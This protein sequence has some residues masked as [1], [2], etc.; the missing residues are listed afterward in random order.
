MNAA[1]RTVRVLIVEGSAAI[2][3]LLRSALSRDGGIAVVGEAPDPHAARELITMLNP[4]VLILDVETPEM[5]GLEFLEE[6]MRRRP[7]PVVTVSTLTGRGADVTLD[8]LALGAADYVPKPADN[9]AAHPDAAA[10]ELIA[11]VRAAAT[12][13]IRTAA[14]SVPHRA[15]PPAAP[16]ASH[17]FADRIIAIGASTGGV[18]AV[19]ELLSRF[20]AN[21]PP[22]LIT[23]P[24]PAGMTASF[25]ARLDKL[26]APWVSEATDCAPLVP[27]QVWLAPG[28]G[29]HLEV[30][31]RIAPR[32]RLVPDGPAGGHCPSVDRLFHSL[33][34][35][36]PRRTV[37]V[38]LT[39]MGRD[40]ADGLGALALAGGETVGQDE[41]SCAVYGMARAAFEMGAVVHQLPLER[42]GPF[43]LDLCRVHETA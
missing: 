28:G 5:Y 15:P 33:A 16:S 10:P 1:S 29:A 25:A 40:G 38:I 42:I 2:R 41:S 35:C 13:R 9:A 21:C 26:C 23:L 22:T 19:L 31:G 18:G 27:G 37:G 32:C 8:A 6:L 39:G 14:H 3:S 34:R 12:A 17:D 11:K 36:H 24:M 20:P 30:S 7:M 4:D 43:V